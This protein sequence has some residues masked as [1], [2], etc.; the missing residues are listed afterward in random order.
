MHVQESVTLQK[1][2]K[3]TAKPASGFRPDIE[4]LRAIAVLSVV[5]Y[6]LSSQWLPGGFVGVDIFFVISGFLITS[7]LV[8]ELER[9]GRISLVRF[10]SRRMIRL[11][12]A[13]TLALIGTL[14]ATVLFVPQYLWRQV[15]T[16]IAAA[17]AYI[18]N[19]VFAARSVDYLAEDSVASPVQH[20]WSL[21]VE[22]QYYVVWPL[23][24]ILVAAL[25]RG[26]KKHLRNALLIA[27]AIVVAFSF[28]AAL[29]AASIGD[30]TAYF[31]TVTRLWELAIGAAAAIAL[32][33]IER[34]ISL[35]LAQIGYLLGIA[36]IGLS[37]VIIT[38]DASWPGPLT[39]LP[40]VG[41]ALAIV[42]GHR[43]GLPARVLSVRPLV[44]IGGIS[45]SLYLWHWP[46]I[47]ISSYVVDAESLLAKFA[48]VVTS[49]IAATLSVRLFENP[50]RFSAWAKGRARNG[51][52]LGL[53]LGAI[54]IVAALIVGAAASTGTLKAPPGATPA[55]AAALGQNLRS[56]DEAAFTD[57]PEWVLPA[58]LDAESDVP[59]LYAD[60]CQQNQTSA[61]VLACDYG[62]LSAE[63]VIAVVGDSKANQWLPALDLIGESTGYR[64][65]VMTKSACS[66]SDA[67]AE[68]AGEA[69]PTC[70]AWNKEV[71]KK[72]A[73]M[74]P[75]A[76]ITSMV[77]SRAHVSG[78]DAAAVSAM[79]EGLVTKLERAGGYTEHV[80]V[81]ADTPHPPRIE[82]QCVASNTSDISPCDFPLGPAQDESAIGVQLEAIGKVGG[83]IVRAEDD[84]TSRS[85]TG[86]TLI[87]MTAAICPEVVAERCPAVIG[88]AMVYRQGSHITATYVATMAPI[89]KDAL[90]SA[91]LEV[92]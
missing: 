55:G 68:L 77:N 31:S 19:W 3:P 72:L 81:I 71:D 35:R 13:A 14:V 63:R 70:D 75:S 60:D 58:P 30:A 67:P 61:E 51:L 27:A 49:F 9:S 57:Q 26:R 90:A 1:A 2:P 17:A 76:I 44:W 42:F 41:T 43:V 91:G 32:P 20:F 11:V 62:D 82:Y 86:E 48:I 5:V 25:V 4:G 23:L 40:T 65:T 47:V 6:H 89:L 29:V 54:S 78:G 37:L 64:I 52:T 87:D 16:D 21:A 22:E 85:A 28:A 15:G 56:V 18:V 24:I 7:H 8:R 45:Y 53:S 34:A 33:W 88:N 92:D 50:I 38:G 83:S 66:F 69:Y 74:Q 12:P 10:Y 46:I 39:L 84:A 59:E 73:K 36:L 79:T 80:L